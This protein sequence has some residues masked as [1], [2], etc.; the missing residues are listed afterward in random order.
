MVTEKHICL[1]VPKSL[2]DKIKIESER[3][4][5]SAN[6]LIRSVLVSYFD[7]HANK[8]YSCNTNEDNV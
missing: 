3:R 6:A 5:I 1:T 7:E 2:F 8:S 4:F